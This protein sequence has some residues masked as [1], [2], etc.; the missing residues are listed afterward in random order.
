MTIGFSRVKT[1]TTGF[2]AR[3]FTYSGLMFE[4]LTNKEYAITFSN[5]MTTIVAH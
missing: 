2:T 3:R 1:S 4:V 5:G